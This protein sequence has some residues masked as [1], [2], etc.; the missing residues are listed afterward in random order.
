[1]YIPMVLPRMMW[2]SKKCYL[3][4][5]SSQSKESEVDIMRDLQMD[6]IKHIVAVRLQEKK[7]ATNAMDRS[8]KKQRILEIIEDKREQEF[9]DMP[10]EELSKML[11]EL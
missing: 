2:K 6:I 4:R 7:E 1:M 10:V 11:Q 3:E 9:R 5:E 8:S